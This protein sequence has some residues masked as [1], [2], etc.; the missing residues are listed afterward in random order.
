LLPSL[1]EEFEG[2]KTPDEIRACTDA[3]LSQFDDTPVRSFVLT[4]AHRRAREC[5]REPECALL[6]H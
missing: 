5:L 2:E 1:V 4:L 6:A 3:V